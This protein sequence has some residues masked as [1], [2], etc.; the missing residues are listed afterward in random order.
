[1][2]LTVSFVLRTIVRSAPVSIPVKRQGLKLNE[3]S[4]GRVLR[5]LR[6]EKGISQEKLAELSGLDRSYVS[7]LERGLRQPSLETLFSIGDSLD[8]S[9]SEIVRMVE[10][11]SRA[12]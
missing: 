9:P 10:K 2:I 4:F 1:M 8:V 11:D 6:S 5:S 7:L 12:T 3:Q